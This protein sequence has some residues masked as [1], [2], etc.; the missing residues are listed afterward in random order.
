MII[1]SW[2]NIISPEPASSAQSRPQ[3]IDYFGDSS[4]PQSGSIASLM[5]KTPGGVAGHINSGCSTD[6]GYILQGAVR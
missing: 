1:A 3:N 2:T 6:E 4:G 5:A